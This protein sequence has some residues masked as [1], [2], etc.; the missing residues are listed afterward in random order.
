MSQSHIAISSSP[1]QA[2]AQSPPLGI[3][4][5]TAQGPEKPLAYL[6]LTPRQAFGV[7]YALIA[8]C[9]RVGPPRTELQHEMAGLRDFLLDLLDE[10]HVA[11]LL[12]AS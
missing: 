7:A 2:P 11:V 9:R 6:E 3:P 5:R 10:A 4:D 12:D 8:H 1:S